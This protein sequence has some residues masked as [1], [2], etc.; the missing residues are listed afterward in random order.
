MNDKRTSLWEK[1][2]TVEDIQPKFSQ[3]RLQVPPVYFFILHLS[4]HILHSFTIATTRVEQ[5]KIRN[6]FQKKTQVRFGQYMTA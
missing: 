6:Q 4:I 3:T 1:K 2:Q 5:S